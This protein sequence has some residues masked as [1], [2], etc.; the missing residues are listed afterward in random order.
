M[1]STPQARVARRVSSRLD[2]PP[3][4][5]AAGA[6]GNT[7]QQGSS[8]WGLGAVLHR[9]RTANILHCLGVLARPTGRRCLV[10][11]ASAQPMLAVDDLDAADGAP[12]RR[13]RQ[14]P[15]HTTAGFPGQQYHISTKRVRGQRRGQRLVVSN[16]A[17]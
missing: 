15:G 12:G 16:T 10:S 3:T 4:H 7:G 9:S 13:A 6:V 1:A 2:T 14:S 5:R 8:D 11:S 17:G